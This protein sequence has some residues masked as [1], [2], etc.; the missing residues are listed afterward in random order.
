MAPLLLPLAAGMI[1]LLLRAQGSCGPAVSSPSSPPPGFCWPWHPAARR[2]ASGADRNLP[3]GQ[4][5][6]AL[7]HRTGFGPAQRP[8]APGDRRAGPARPCCM[9]AMAT[10]ARQGLSCALSHAAAGHQ[11]RLPD[12]RPVQPLR[13]FR[14]PAHRLLL[15]GPARRG[16]GADA[17]RLHYVVLNLIGSSLFLVAVGTLYGPAGTLNM[18]DLAGPWRPRP[19]AGRAAARPLRC[20]W[21]CSVSRPRSCRCMWLPALYAA[22]LPSVAALFA[23]MT[24]VGLYAILRTQSLIF[25]P[26]PGRFPRPPGCCRPWRCSP[27]RQEPSGCSAREPAGNPRLPG[28]RLRRHSAGRHR[29]VERSRASPPPSTICRTPPWSPP[30][31]FCWPISSP[32]SAAPGR[33]PGPGPPSGPA[34][35]LGA[36]FLLGPWPPPVCRRSPVSSARCCCCRRPRPADALWLWTSSCLPGCWA[37]LPGAPAA[38]VLENRGGI[39]SGAVGLLGRAAPALALL[40][41]GRGPD[42]PGRSGQP[43][44]PRPPHSSCNPRT[45][46]QPSWEEKAMKSLAAATDC[47]A[48][49]CGWSGCCWPTPRRRARWSWAVL[50]LACRCSPCASGPTGRACQAAQAAVYIAVC[51]GTSSSPT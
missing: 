17:R 36:L 48:C 47:S 29:P 23:I 30:A 31:C 38:A 44:T 16:A 37:W 10:T 11:R 6:G 41:A 1:N 49:S 42:G 25:T 22:A 40:L 3:T 21:W 9:P 24:K 50:A 18:A 32:A 4:L 14:N 46:S 39:D 15:P 19:G 7:R 12:R 33:H 51:S 8:A 2:A 43:A 5:A 35:R 28:H 45:T 13:L 27:W 34:G 20:C 26:R